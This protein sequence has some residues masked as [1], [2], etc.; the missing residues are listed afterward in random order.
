MKIKELLESY[1]D[2]NPK[3]SYDLFMEYQENI[4]ELIL[5]GRRLKSSQISYEWTIIAEQYLIQAKKLI[6]FIKPLLHT[7]IM[8][9]ISGNS[10]WSKDKYAIFLINHAEEELEKMEKLFASV[11]NKIPP[12]TTIHES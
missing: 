8:I 2:I 10:D 4:L 6:D 11:T 12:N 1:D 9:L 7:T 3:D 5:K